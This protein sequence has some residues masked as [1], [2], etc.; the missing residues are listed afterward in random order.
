MGSK[1]VKISEKGASGSKSVALAQVLVTF[2]GVMKTQL[3]LLTMEAVSPREVSSPS[4]K[5][6][7]A[8]ADWFW[9]FI[10]SFSILDELGLVWTTRFNLPP[11]SL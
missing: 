4:I 8:G 5:E 3:P 6:I 2:V 9:I 10:K 7:S 1:K 11:S